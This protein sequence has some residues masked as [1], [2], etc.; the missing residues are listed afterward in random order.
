MNPNSNFKSCPQHSQI[1]P[2]KTPSPSVTSKQLS[3]WQLRGCDQLQYSD[4]WQGQGTPKVP[5]G[6]MPTL[7]PIGTAASMS[8]LGSAAPTPLRGAH[9]MWYCWYCIAGDIIKVAACH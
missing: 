9:L 2:L 1:I 6:L 7:L 4:S 8:H 3:Q 5:Q